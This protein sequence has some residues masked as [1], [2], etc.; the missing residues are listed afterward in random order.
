MI[1]SKSLEEVKSI[2]A[3]NDLVV[4]LISSTACS[5]CTVAKEKMLQLA[6][7]DNDIK[8]VSTY[9][10]DDRLISGEFLVFTAPTILV[11]DN[12]KEILRESRFINYGKIDRIIDLCKN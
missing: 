1:Q 11:F 6:N 2:I 5:V 9:I 12:G 4:L 8:V 3:S 10:E 7:R